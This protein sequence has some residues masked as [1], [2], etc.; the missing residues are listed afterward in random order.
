MRKAVT[1]VM[2]SFIFLSSSQAMGFVY[3][4]KFD[5]SKI[6]SN[7][8]SI[9]TSGGN[10]IRLDTKNHRV[11]M[12]QN[13]QDGSCGLVFDK[14]PITGDFDAQVDYEI[15]Y[16]P[17]LYSGGNQMR[18]G[19]S[20]SCSGGLVANVQHVS[21]YWFSCSEDSPDV[22][23]THFR[24]CG[25]TDEIHPWCRSADG[26]SILTSD[27][28]GRLRIK[29]DGA[30]ISTYYASTGS[31]SWTPIWTMEN[32]YSGE[33]TSIGLA[34]WN[35]YRDETGARIAFDN[36]YIT[37]HSLSASIVARPKQVEIDD[38]IVVKMEVTNYGKKAVTDLAPVDPLSVSPKGSVVLVDGPTP[39]R[40]KLSPGKSVTFR[41]N[42]KALKHGQVTFSG[43]ARGNADK[44]GVVT[45]VASNVAKSNPVEIGIQL[46][47]KTIS[48]QND[49]D[50]R[51]SDNSPT[52][53]PQYDAA[54][55]RADPV[56]FYFGAN[57]T[58]RVKFTARNVAEET[59]FKIFGRAET[60][61]GPYMLF[62]PRTVTFSP[63][64]TAVT[65][66][67]ELKPPSQFGVEKISKISW[68]I[69]DSEGGTFK[70]HE[71]EFPIYI[72]LNAPIR[73]AKQPRVELLDIA[74]DTVAGKSDRGEI[75]NQMTKGIYHW[76]QKRGL[77]YDGGCGT[78]VTGDYSNLT[79][80]LTGLM[81]PATVAGDCRLASALY[82]VVL[83]A[84][85]IDMRL[86][87]ASNQFGKQFETAP[88][89]GY[90][91]DQFE[92]FT[93]EKHQFAVIHTING[94]F[95]FD[96]TL[97]FQDAPAFAIRMPISYY[98]MHL[99]PAYVMSSSVIYFD[100]DTIQ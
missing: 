37:S 72:I 84:I 77:V 62:P 95:V 86:L 59:T 80:D 16:M 22:Y 17:Q 76:L 3:E 98:L 25:A 15:L 40:A 39:P 30:T 60:S 23:L 58:A 42:Y 74:A 89:K 83:N 93:F 82:Q 45:F 46:Q 41:Y 94:D 18:V 90:G 57:P 75:R 1:V 24:C 20:A 13:G 7:W 28:K 85:G 50:M 87:E 70:S 9:S 32:C 64:Q 54:T 97:C 47:V 49:V 36:F 68:F 44:P 92:T 31:N 19:L 79:L 67:Y 99:A 63:S 5:G 69:R 26:Y 6:D 51:R 38:T 100:V 29:R 71:T 65:E 48:F 78:L 96:P 11:V 55:G 53:K 10:K 81:H 35:G 8:W 43:K 52:E 4:D 14:H 27:K 21:D 88:V 91:M 2:M 34:I 61:S 56:A 33:L 73:A 12:T 66:D